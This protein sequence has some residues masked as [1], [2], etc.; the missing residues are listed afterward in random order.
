LPPE[1]RPEGFEMVWDVQELA[2]GADDLVLIFTASLTNGCT[3]TLESDALGVPLDAR[4]PNFTREAVGSHPAV[5]GTSTDGV[6]VL[7]WEQ[8]EGVVGHFSCGD[9]GLDEA[10]ALRIAESIEPVTADDPRL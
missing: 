6:E 3:V 5:L 10:T 9:G 4:L 1:A 8:A 2:V 7:E